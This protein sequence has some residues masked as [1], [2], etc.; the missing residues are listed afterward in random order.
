MSIA[1]VMKKWE[2]WVKRGMFWPFVHDPVKGQPSVT[3]MFFY[4]GFFM[5]LLCIGASSILMMIKGDFL[6]ATTM[7]TM[8]MFSTFIF[9]RLR[10]LDSVKINLQEKSLD[11][12]GSSEDEEK[13]E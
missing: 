5:A 13:S 2:S 6:S 1:E 11:L 12:S 8:L 3:L 10:R 9:Y 4:L 7:P